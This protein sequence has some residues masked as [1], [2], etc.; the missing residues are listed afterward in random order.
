VAYDIPTTEAIEQEY[1]AKRGFVDLSITPLAIPNYLDFHKKEQINKHTFFRRP[2]Q[3]LTNQR[4][5]LDTQGSSV[6]AK[7]P[8]KGLAASASFNG[9]TA[10][11][12]SRTSRARVTAGE[13]ATAVSRGKKLKKVKVEHSQGTEYSINSQTPTIP[14]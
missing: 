5:P 12:H 14:F 7:F 3:R 4:Y 10:F 11:S 2:V 8:S 6:T 1:S 9:Y 13:G